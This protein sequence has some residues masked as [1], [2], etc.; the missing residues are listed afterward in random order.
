MTIFLLISIWIGFIT[1]SLI[2]YGLDFIDSILLGFSFGLLGGAIIYK[3]IDKIWKH[4]K[5]KL[6][7][8]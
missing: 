4:L 5:Q 3:A 1:L 6:D 8:D 7:T 2:T